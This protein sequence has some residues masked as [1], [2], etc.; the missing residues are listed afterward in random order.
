MSPWLN[1]TD[2]IA[3]RRAD[4]CS[5]PLRGRG[6]G[7]DGG[8]FPAGS[9]RTQGVEPYGMRHLHRLGVPIFGVMLLGVGSWACSRDRPA[10]ESKTSGSGG[11]GGTGGTGG[12][13]GAGGAGGAYRYRRSSSCWGCHPKLYESWRGSM[14]YRPVSP[15]GL[16]EA[17]V[18]P[19]SVVVPIFTI[20]RCRGE[21][22]L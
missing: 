19:G 14:K 21:L 1:S 20:S 2:S 6:S 18:V 10:A 5:G 8:G 7:F 15:A 11:A 16:A 3:R 4:Q 12:T 9:S 13:G 22:K 17:K